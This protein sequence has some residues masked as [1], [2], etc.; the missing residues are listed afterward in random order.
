MI[1]HNNI[2]LVN[3]TEFI[4]VNFREFFRVNFTEFFLLRISAMILILVQSQLSLILC[5]LVVYNLFC[6]RCYNHFNR[7][8]SY[9]LFP[10]REISNF[11]SHP[12]HR[13]VRFC[14]I[15]FW[16][17]ILRLLHQHL[18]E[19]LLLDSVDLVTYNILP[20][21]YIKQWLNGISWAAWLER[22]A[23]RGTLD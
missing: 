10:N 19:L 22:K 1:Q 18:V 15:S 8:Q 4:L 13:F 23:L 17:P 2:I 20:I 21:T 9:P 14:S 3:F 7:I 5:R 6:I 16:H 12:F 11:R